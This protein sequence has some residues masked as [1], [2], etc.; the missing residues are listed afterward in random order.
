MT[1][2]AAAKLALLENRQF[3]HVVKIVLEAISPLSVGG[4]EDSSIFD[5]ALLRDANGLPTIQGSTLAGVLRHRLCDEPDGQTLAD[6]LFGFEEE[7]GGAGQA[8]RITISF[9]AAL[10]AKGSPV[11]GLREEQALLEDQVLAIL[12]HGAPLRRDHVS[13]DRRGVADERKKYDRAAVP[14]GT[15]F[16]FELTMWG[17]AAGC[18]TDKWKFRRLV[19]IISDPAF[20]LGGA[21]R[22]GYGQ[23]RV[24]R[25]RWR[26][27][28]VAVDRP[29]TVRQVRASGPGDADGFSALEP[30][31]PASALSACHGT[32][33]LRPVG[34]WRIGQGDV[35][36]SSRED[37]AGDA[38]KADALPLTE[39]V[40]V[41]GENGVGRICTAAQPSDDED[42]W[43][44]VP[45][46]AIKGPLAH[47]A[48]Y[49]YLR[50]AGP[51]IEF[52]DTTSK[53]KDEELATAASPETLSEVV[54]R[55]FGRD[56]LSSLLGNAKSRDAS[57]ERSGD[58]D[59]G[60]AGLLMIDDSS[61]RISKKDQIVHIMHNSIDRFTG[62]VRGGFLFSEEAVHGGELRIG[63]HLLRGNVP[64]DVKR[65]FCLALKD[66]CEG[67]IAIGA[68]RLGFAKGVVQW[69]DK[70]WLSGIKPSDLPPLLC[71]ASEAAA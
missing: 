55:L 19:R 11:R 62:G 31:K 56:V 23:I 4:G 39:P 16:A 3:L 35:A 51:M 47:R 24:E 68:K 13:I 2:A 14:K 57:D 37:G 12:L 6:E 36:L 21:T 48:L 15:R 26:A 42:V 8:A 46:S 64:F 27:I 25:A 71:R 38:N 28:D 17:T 69:N 49:H 43:L 1:T 41:W 65:A 54:D 9:G 22:R 58:R 60:R 7:G 29:Q 70:E 67:R 59:R 33:V 52:D 40:I 32:I 50:I 20:R 18:E 66:L 63:F 44:S 5:T 10:D 61:V 34:V 53:P 30:L 45:A